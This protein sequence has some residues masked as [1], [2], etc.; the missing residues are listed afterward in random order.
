MNVCRHVHIH[1]YIDL[2]YIR[3]VTGIGEKRGK[4]GGIKNIT[5]S[6]RC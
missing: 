4:K 1:K 5:Y 6:L 2:L 3:N